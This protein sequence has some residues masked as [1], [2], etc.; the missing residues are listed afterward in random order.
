MVFG[1]QENSAVGYNRRY[2]GKRSYDPLLCIE[3]NSSYLWDTELRPGNAGTWDGSLEI[4]FFELP[5]RVTAFTFLERHQLFRFIPFSRN[6]QVCDEPQ[7]YGVNFLQH[8]AQ[9]TTTGT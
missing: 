4:P 8:L 5:R 3:A 2:R 7:G 9:R 6:E 1:K